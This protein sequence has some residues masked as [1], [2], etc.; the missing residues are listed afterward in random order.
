MGVRRKQTDFSTAIG[1]HR[2]AGSHWTWGAHLKC[3]EA[4]QRLGWRCDK[5][6]SWVHPLTE[7][8]GVTMGLA[9][10]QRCVL[11]ATDPDDLVVGPT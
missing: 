10:T 6:I 1:H 8:H 11:M 2:R 5:E 3:V 4:A 7:K 9:V